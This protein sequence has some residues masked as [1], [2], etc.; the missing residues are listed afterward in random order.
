MFTGM[1]IGVFIGANVGLLI[2]AL[3]LAAKQGDYYD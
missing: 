3:C 1:I 2:L